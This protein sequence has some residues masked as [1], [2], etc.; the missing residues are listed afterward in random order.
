[1]KFY[2]AH[3]KLARLLHFSTFLLNFT[4]VRGKVFPSHIKWFRSRQKT[5]NKNV[6]KKILN[7]NALF[8]FNAFSYSWTL[9]ISP[10]VYPKSHINGNEKSI[11]LP[12]A[13]VFNKFEIFSGMTICS[14]QYIL[15]KTMFFAPGNLLSSVWMFFSLFSLDFTKQI[16]LF[17]VFLC[18]LCTSRPPMIYELKSTS[19]PKLFCCF[20]PNYLH[21]FFLSFFVL[22]PS[23]DHRISVLI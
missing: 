11:F 3:Y 22:F 5:Q 6:C 1:M 15:D 18:S 19:S 23:V 20:S 17:T 16:F 8:G 13:Y 9:P 2:S 4:D 21:N 12:F 7:W 14:E 10:F